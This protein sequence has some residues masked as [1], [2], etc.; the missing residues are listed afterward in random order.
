MNKMTDVVESC[1]EKPPLAG[2]S[3]SVFLGRS[4]VRVV[5]EEGG[6]GQPRRQGTESSDSEGK[7]LN[8]Y[9]GLKGTPT[10]L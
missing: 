1:T 6:R 8:K 7:S 10:M 2:E 9:E 4:A 3:L 5:P